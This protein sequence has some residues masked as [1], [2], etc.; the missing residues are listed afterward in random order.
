MIFYIA[1]MHFWHANV[2]RFDS[3]P[4][5]D[6]ESMTETMVRNW[7]SRVTAEDTVYVIGD[8]FWR[9]E[10]AGIEII[11]QLNGH[12]HLIRGNHDRVRGRLQAYWESIEQYAEIVD[13]GFQVVMCHY[14]IL[15]YKNQHR[16]A[17]MLYGHVH[18]TRE[19]QFVEKWKN[20]QWN[21]GIPSRIIN[22]GCM[23]EYMGYTPRTLDELLAANPLPKGI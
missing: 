17:I 8:A 14:P 1:D 22:V 11:R 19:W 20:E 18:N 16:G 2:I 6:T 15:F 4:F 12:K 9:N 5:A 10:E 21:A 13:N 7:N 3:R 23:M